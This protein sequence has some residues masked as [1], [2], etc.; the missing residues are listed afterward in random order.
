MID[1][2]QLVGGISFFATSI[3]LRPNRAFARSGKILIGF[4]AAADPAGVYAAQEEGFYKEAGL[5]TELQLVALN[6]T[7]PGALQSAS[8]QFAN[9]SPPV[10][11]SAIDGGLDLVA[12]GSTSV[13]AKGVKSF[14]AVASPSLK[15]KQAA[16]FYGK[17]VGV[18]GLNAFLH[19]VFRKW[20][21]DQGADASQVTFVE[22]P[23]PQMADVM[24][25]G[26]IDAVIGSEP[27]VGRIVASGAGEIITHMDDLAHELPTAFLATTRDFAAENPDAVRAFQAGTVKGVEFAQNNLEKA[28]E[29]VAKYTKLDLEA[30]KA[31]P[32]PRLRATATVDDVRNWIDLMKAQNM[33][34]TE[35]DPEQ[36]VFS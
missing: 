27:I 22:V 9:P 16:D 33:I 23:F 14:A 1:R 10:F 34:R 20:M 31:V 4:T 28:Q 19:V 21:M 12:V 7:I 24:R 6:P 26:S 25:G 29:Y 5:D 11:V 32:F 17:R 35:I 30:I 36:C 8:L 18:P 2:R 15:I 3:A 13:I